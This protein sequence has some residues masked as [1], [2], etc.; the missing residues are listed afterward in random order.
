MVVYLPVQ[1]VDRVLLLLLPHL[2][3]SRE[4]ALHGSCSAVQGLIYNATLPIGMTY[5]KI[6]SQNGTPLQH[7]KG[8]HIM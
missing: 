7:S 4:Q 1:G 8:G 3:L 5:R 2:L 6:V